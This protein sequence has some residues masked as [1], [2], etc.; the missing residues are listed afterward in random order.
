M[1]QERLAFETE[2]IEAEVIGQ[3]ES[4]DLYFD[5][6]QRVLCFTFF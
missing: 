5:D 4:D 6:V 2:D 1:L 3:L